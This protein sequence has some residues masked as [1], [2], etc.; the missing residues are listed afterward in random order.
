[1]AAHREN[2]E[3]RNSDYFNI[4]S[5]AVFRDSGI[6]EGPLLSTTPGT[7][8]IVSHDLV[9]WMGDLNYRIVGEIPTEEVLRRTDDNDI[10]FLLEHDQLN[11][12]RRSGKVF[13]GFEE[14]RITFP[15]TY[16]YQPGTNV[17]ERR[18]DKKL[19][20]PAW[21]DR[22]LWKQSRHIRQERYFRAELTLSDHKPVAA[23]FRVNVRRIVKEEQMRVYEELSRAWDALENDS[24]PKITIHPPIIDFSEI[25]YMVKAESQ[26]VIENVGQVP[27]QFRFVPKLEE[28]E[29]CKPWLIVSPPFGVISTNDSVT[30]TLTACIDNH[31]AR[32]LNSGSDKL[33][34]V[35]ILRL[36]NGVDYFVS[37]TGTYL[38]SCFG[39]TLTY[40]VLH[41]A[42]IRQV[43]D[44]EP[45]STSCLAVPKELW[46]IVDYIYNQGMDVKGLFTERGNPSEVELI[47][48]CLD[49][50][51]S[52][53]H[54]SVHSMAEAMIQL[55][56][57]LQ[58]PVISMD[59][60]PEVD[61]GT[62]NLQI[63]GRRF[64]E[65]LPAMN[66]NVFVYIISFLRELLKQSDSN[67][68]KP[69]DLALVFSGC[70]IRPWEQAKAQLYMDSG[71]ETKKLSNFS[72]MNVQAF[73]LHFLATDAF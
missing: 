23:L 21:C 41:S 18:P 71:F 32:E 52:F 45:P 36:Q 2:V 54:F 13:Q 31:T 15:P 25:R 7:Y 24:M 11:Q 70:L 22:I 17:Y 68:L 44:G 9:F 38:K 53:E 34:D 33:D 10:A 39:Q 1:M 46:R 63:W 49:T 3:G 56:D 62:A 59:L 43:T 40:L 51:A 30:I 26:L 5:K 67:R 57:S 28:V 20:A 29:F 60:L 50:G 69:A 35:L 66:Y 64:L 6:S 42:P 12:E 47:R 19:R 37:I 55:L 4:L 61:F 73:L 14:G 72:T 58:E 27:V 48:E 8:G 65:Q 16:K